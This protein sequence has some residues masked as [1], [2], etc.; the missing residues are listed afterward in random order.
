VNIY[1]KLKHKTNGINKVNDNNWTWKD[2]IIGNKNVQVIEHQN[3]LIQYVREINGD[4]EM[5]TMK[6]RKGRGSGYIYNSFK[7][8]INGKR[9]SWWFIRY[10]DKRTVDIK[11][12]YSDDK[13]QYVAVDGVK[14]KSAVDY[15]EACLKI[16]LRG[17]TI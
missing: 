13:L 2:K 15:G 10:I 1:N 11:V 12:F 8:W 17:N 14:Y 16:E 9:E 4:I 5:I 6:E 7:Y 3:G